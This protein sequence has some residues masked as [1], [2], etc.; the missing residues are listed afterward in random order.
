ML[1]IYPV[2]TRISI[3]APVPSPEHIHPALWRASQLS[4]APGRF[5]ASGFSA[6]DEQLPGGGW[7][8]GHLIDVGARQPGIG[9]LQLFRTALLRRKDRP[10][11]LVQ[12]PH[13]PSSAA[14]SSW[15]GQTPGLVWANT[16]RAADALWAAEQAVRSG[17]FAG[18]FLWQDHAR[19]STLRRLQLAAQEGDTLFSVIRPLRSLSGAS[20]APLRL[21]LSPAPNGLRV[22][23]EKRRG[24][25]CDK[26]IDIPLYPATS[27]DEFHHAHVDSRASDARLPRQPLPLVAH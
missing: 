24:A 14:W 5:A 18:V 16:S 3:M 19:N 8:L 7:P 13:R 21:A 9:E 23:I 15:G 20:P 10:V 6:L 22:A 2:F 4:V 17:S 1:Y 27:R 11:L 12:P 26:I 25:T